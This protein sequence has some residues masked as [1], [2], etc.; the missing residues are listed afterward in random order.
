MKKLLLCILVSASLIACTNQETKTEAKIEVTPETTGTV[1]TTGP[2]VDLMKNS[3]TY[4]ANGDWAKLASCYADSAK[5]FHNVWASSTDTTVGVNL[6]NIIEGFKKQ[7]EL[8]DGNI[9]LG[10]NIYEVVTMPDGNKYG[11]SWLEMSWKS[12]KGVTGK[13]VIFSSF[14]FNKDGKLTFHWPIYDTKD[15]VNLK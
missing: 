14:G 9:N 12:K 5:A 6:Q 10:R 3:F 8:I 2:D 1:T 4:F 7:R 11:H 13:M 15:V